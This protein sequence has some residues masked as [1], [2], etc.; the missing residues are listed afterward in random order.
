MLTFLRYSFPLLEDY[1]QWVQ[2]SMSY[3]RYLRMLEQCVP[4]IRQR[5]V[6]CRSCL[7]E[8]CVCAEDPYIIPLLHSKCLIC[9][10]FEC[11]CYI[12]AE[13]GVLKPVPGYLNAIEIKS[14]ETLGHSRRDVFK[15]INSYISDSNFTEA[16][17][18]RFQVGYDVSLHYKQ[19][20][21]SPLNK[22]WIK[23]CSSL[24]PKTCDTNRRLLRF[25]H[26]DTIT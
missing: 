1:S 19:C 23:A 2:T 3:I 15:Y 4:V 14:I 18:L 24:S 26:G 9:G 5:G 7:K 20:T 25:A 13:F 21:C 16:Q 22:L 12:E 6:I 11:Q 17:F 8:I 10:E